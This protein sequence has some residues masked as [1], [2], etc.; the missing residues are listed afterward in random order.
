M[1]KYSLQGVPFRGLPLA[2]QTTGNSVQTLLDKQPL[3]SG[4]ALEKP[5]IRRCWSEA[6]DNISLKDLLIDAIRC[7]PRHSI[8]ARMEQ[9]ID[10]ALDTSHLK[11]LMARNALVENHEPG[12]PV[13]H[14]RRNGQG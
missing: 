2:A 12:R 9:V 11:D 5:V 3:A 1:R 8:R 13:C 10:Q 4:E 14:P 7:S 6:F